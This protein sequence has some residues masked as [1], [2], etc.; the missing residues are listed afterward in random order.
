MAQAIPQALDKIK[1][2]PQESFASTNS[3][4]VY[5]GGKTF[6]TIQAAIDSITDAS[7]E[8]QYQVVIGPGTYNEQVTLKPYVVLAGSGQDKTIIS[9][10]PSDYSSRGTVRG[11]SFSG[12]YDL[13][14]ISAGGSWGTWA[15]AL[16]LD[17]ADTF[18]AQGVSFIVQDNGNAGVNMI[19]V[20]IDRDSNGNN[21]SSVTFGSVLI[22]SDATNNQ[23]TSSGLSIAQN[24]KMQ[25]WLSHILASGGSQSFGATS[26]LGANLQLD[27]STISGST[28][29]LYIPCGQPA[30]LVA[31][32]CTINGPVSPGVQ[33]NKNP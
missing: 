26:W 2:L 1:A 6:S 9:R 3:I 12:I 29:A 14:V 20:G 24:A 16:Y 23:S 31:N 27:E 8:V 22:K 5:P 4:T 13:A 10:A 18:E 25:V 15:V 32:D 33:V 7:P 21:P 19:A 30:T 28:Y 17:Q 11:A